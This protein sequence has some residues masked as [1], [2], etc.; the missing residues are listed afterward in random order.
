M[1]LTSG[2]CSRILKAASRAKHPRDFETELF[3]KPSTPPGLRVTELAKLTP[4]DVET[5]EKL[6]RVVLGKGKKDRTVPLT[7]EAASCHRDLSREG[8]SEAPR[9]EERFGGFSLGSRGGRLHRA[10]LNRI[11]QKW[12]RKPK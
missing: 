4:Y 1:V 3:S 12:A 2:K 11:V 9:L 5:E 8:T 10:T 6:L 7:Q